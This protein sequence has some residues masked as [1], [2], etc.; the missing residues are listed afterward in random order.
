MLPSL[1]RPPSTNLAETYLGTA[2]PACMATFWRWKIPVVETLT[3][4]G[5]TAPGFP[6]TLTA[7]RQDSSARLTEAIQ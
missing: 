5:F 4:F 3:L 2:D 1:P 7:T 6:N